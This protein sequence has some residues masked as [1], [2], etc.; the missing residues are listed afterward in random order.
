M[1]NCIVGSLTLVL[2]L[3]GS[4]ATGADPYAEIFTFP[5]KVK[6]DENQKKKLEAL[7]KT[8]DPQLTRMDEGLR[9]G[10]Y[11]KF[12]LPGQA[13]KGNHPDEE[14]NPDGRATAHP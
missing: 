10:E 9:R 4:F 6:L 2:F 5:E 8:Y 1:K 14:R 12:A 3:G 7:R 11:P 13:R